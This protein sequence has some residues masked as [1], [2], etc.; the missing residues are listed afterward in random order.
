VKGRDNSG[1]V[2]DVQH[3]TAE[4]LPTEVMKALNLFSI[5]IILLM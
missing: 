1:E 2:S 4:A 5:I 3:D